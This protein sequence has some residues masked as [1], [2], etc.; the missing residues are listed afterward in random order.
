VTLSSSYKHMV[1][2]PGGSYRAGDERFYPEEGPVDDVE[3]GPVWVD[4]HP[5]TNAEFRRF[6]KDTGHVTVAETE[7]D[8]AEFDG[9]DEELLVP[10]SLVFAPSSGPVPL[11]DW[12]QWWRWLPGTDWRHPAGP[13]STLD[14]L[15]RNPVVH[16]GFEDA[17]AYA[18]WAGKALPDEAEWEYAAR[19]G[20]VGATFAWGDDFTPRGKVMAN[21]W[22]GRFPWENLRPQGRTGTSP[23]GKFPPNG[24][25]LHDVTGNVW[26]W[27]VSRWSDDRSGVSDAAAGAAAERAAAAPSCCAPTSPAVA[28]AEVL[29]EEDRR[30]TKG[31]SH[32]CAPSYCLRYRPAARQGHTVRSSTGHLGFRCIVRG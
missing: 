18:G 14:G 19:G 17:V 23:V 9:A 8:P 12:T 31:G 27:T 6:V 4:E 25:G 1:H 32:L 7:P 26:E 10:G 30:V 3:V 24:F 20:L 16:V 28:A 22:H 11:D 15:D 2:L 13:G 5:V 29:H 21:T